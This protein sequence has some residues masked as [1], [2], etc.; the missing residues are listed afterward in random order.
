MGAV[1]TE[2]NKIVDLDR[3]PIDDPD[4]PGYARSLDEAGA[5]LAATGCAVVSGL[6]RPEAVARMSD[7]VVAMR[8][9]THYSTIEINPYFSEPDP[10]LPPDHPVNFLIER[11]S[12]F[13]PRDSFR[14]DSEIAVLWQS[15]EL[16]S[17]LA[18]ALD[19]PE[20]HP[21]ADPLAG[22]TINVLDSGQQFSWHYD[23][24]DIAVTVLLDEAESGG[25]FE[26]VPDIRSGSDENYEG[27]ALA[28]RDEHPGVISLELRPGDMQVFRGRNSL[29]RVTRVAGSAS[30]HAAIFAYTNEADVIGRLERTKQLFGRALPAHERAERE[31]VRSDGLRD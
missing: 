12:G 16:R 5:G 27:V 30:R 13:I 2:L 31:R 24:N 3:H 17:F 28:Q 9:T 6:V 15:P 1:T 29:H 21:Y 4:S 23:T 26:Y 25:I 11:S 19:R 22:L 20:V 18:D 8:P 7:E 14:P 10:D